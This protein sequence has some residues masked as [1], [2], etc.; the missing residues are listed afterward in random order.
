[1]KNK[2][3]KF[4]DTLFFFY[5]NNFRIA[6]VIIKSNL[7]SGIVLPSGRRIGAAFFI[8]LSISP[9][10]IDRSIGNGRVVSAAHIAGNRCCGHGGAAFG[11]PF[12]QIFQYN[13]NCL[14]YQ[15]NKKKYS[16]KYHHFIVHLQF[17]LVYTLI[18]IFLNS[19]ISKQDSCH[20]GRQK[21]CYFYSFGPDQIH[22]HAEDQNISH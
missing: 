5:I 19:N 6:A 16:R 2:S 10:M 14:K 21:I 22:A 4:Q 15:P 20:K 18:H 13:R 11:S 7:I 17:L 8:F 12:S 9:V 1:M 3:N